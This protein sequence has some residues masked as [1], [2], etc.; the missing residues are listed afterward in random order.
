[1]LQYVYISSICYLEVSSNDK[2]LQYLSLLPK[3]LFNQNIR[4]NQKEAFIIKL[5]NLKLSK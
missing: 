4:R 1:M 3:K 2:E 5:I